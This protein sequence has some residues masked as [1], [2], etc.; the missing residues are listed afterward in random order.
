MNDLTLSSVMSPLCSL[1][2]RAGISISLLLTS[3]RALADNLNLDSQP[4]FVFVPF[5]LVLSILLLSVLRLL[6]L[7]IKKRRELDEFKAIVDFSLEF[8]YLRTVQ[9]EYQY[10]SPAVNEITGYSSEEFYNTPNFMD[11]IIH[12][13]DVNNWSDHVHFVNDDGQPEKVEFRIVKKN[14]EVRWLEHLC[15]Q[16]HNA[17]GKLMGVRSINID[18]TERKRAT[19]EVEKLSLFDPLTELPNRRYLDNYMSELIASIEKGSEKRSFSVIFVDL[20]RFKYVNDAYGHSVGDELL[21][22]VSNRFKASCIKSESTM[23]SR[24][25]GDEFVVIAKNRTDETSVKSCVDKMNSLLEMPFNIQGHRLSVGLSAGV[26]VYPNDG[27]TPETLIK[28]ADAA[29]YRAKSQAMKMA[30]FSAELEARASEMVVLERKL[31]QALSRGLIKP[32]YQPQ[33]NMRT[34]ETVGAE[35][36]ARWISLDGRQ[37]PSPAVFIPVSEETGL[38]WELN[39]KVIS[40]AGQDIVGW[41]KDGV[42]IKYSI[43]V[44]ARQFTDENFCDQAI[45]KFESIGI[46]P[47]N[48]QI[49][50]TES[51]LLDNIDRSIEK[52]LMLK[53]KGFSIALDD[54]GT[55]FASLH[56]LTIFPLDTLKI[57]RAFVTNILEDKRRFSIAK[58]IINLA[59]D[60][61]LQV[62]AEGIETEE[63]RNL[64]LELGCEIGQGYLFSKPVPPEELFAR[65]VS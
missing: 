56:Y 38:I 41:Q 35:V 59:K 3:S 2:M 6:F 11:S 46:D 21:R 19:L 45:E 58:S 23:I 61:E 25:G 33:V 47:S 54:F 17:K 13:E 34:N 20:D 18:I 53:S 39:E 8:T 9:G 12:P 48:V 64:L 30:L 51:V 28:N 42:N 52:V 10:V 43:N 15:G 16:V 60:L 57:D 14:G 44:S 62:I 55:G 50:L 1:L 4:D 7:V 49:E 26:A 32:Y 36:L 31:K 5:A 63:Q 27:S 40:Q 37:M 22:Q 65:K 24:F 29:M